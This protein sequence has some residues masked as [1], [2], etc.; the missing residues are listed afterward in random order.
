MSKPP[1]F[2]R[3][4]RSPQVAPPSWMLS[5]MRVSRRGSTAVS[6]FAPTEARSEAI[7]T[8]KYSWYERSCP[9]GLPAGECKEHP[10]ARA[11][12]M[13]PEGEWTRWFLMAGRGFGKTKAGAEWVRFLAE[14]ELASRI[15]LVGP[16]AADVR[17]VMVESVSGV[18][19]VC[20]PR[21]R[22]LYRPSLRQIVWPNG[23]VAAC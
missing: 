19:A 15:A 10:R 7:D 13:P 4:N 12:Q 2:P 18:L 6:L 1:V 23:V 5:T 3:F 17:D 9:C 8:A 14:K 22:P 21:F 11:S 20:P 16:T